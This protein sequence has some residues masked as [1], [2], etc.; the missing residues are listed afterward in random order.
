MW[1]AGHRVK[2]VERAGRSL[3]NLLWCADPWGGI[4]CTSL[5][6]PVCTS[7]QET[8][9]CKVPNIVYLNTCLICKEE[10]V[11]AQYV[12]ETSRTLYERGKEHHAD[13]RKKN[14]DRSH[15]GTHMLEYHPDE[16]P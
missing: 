4:P 10:G 5:D 8:Q 9:I 13:A 3:K 14:S 15:I 2:L 1:M 11:T 6:C 7:D 16:D 12:G